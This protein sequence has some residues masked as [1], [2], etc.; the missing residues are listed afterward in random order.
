[1]VPNSVIALNVDGAEI[2][3]IPGYD[4]MY[5]S[6]TG[7]CFSIR[8]PRSYMMHPKFAHLHKVADGI[9]AKGK[10]TIYRLEAMTLAFKD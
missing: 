5:M 4:G 3:P 2:R 1:M 10:R 7:Q 9:T 8:Q 6:R